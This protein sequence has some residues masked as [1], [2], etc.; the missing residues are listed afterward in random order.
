VPTIEG[1]RGSAGLG[2]IGPE[3][4]RTTAHRGGADREKAGVCREKGSFVRQ[5]R[6]SDPERTFTAWEI[7]QKGK[8][9]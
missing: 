9:L 2:P 7:M 8:G 3:V 6:G 5:K 1:T 4:R